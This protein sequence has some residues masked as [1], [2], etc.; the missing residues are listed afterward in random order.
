MDSD[1]SRTTGAMLLLLSLL[2]HILLLLFIFIF[3]TAPR[4]AQQIEYIDLKNQLPLDPLLQ[5][6]QQSQQQQM[7]PYDPDHEILVDLIAQGMNPNDALTEQP[8][9]IVQDTATPIPGTLPQEEVTAEDAQDLDAETEDEASTQETV[10]QPEEPMPPAQETPKEA[11]TLQELAD[12][13][14]A[15]LPQPAALPA[16][17]TA[18]KQAA[19]KIVRKMA[20]RPPLTPAQAQ[21]LSKLAQGFMQSTHAERGGTPSDD[22]AQLATQR[23]TTKI[24][25]YLKQT[26]NAEQNAMVLSKDVNTYIVLKITLNKQGK[27]V[28]VGCDGPQR[29]RDVLK[30]EDAILAAVRK[31]GLFPPMPD[32]FKKDQYTIVLPIHIRLAQGIGTVSLY[33][34]DDR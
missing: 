14:T 11:F 33:V 31:V 2:L 25:N 6:Q 15:Q 27:L 24:W 9:E 34:Q 32:S 10:E 28:D 7:D 20:Q 4:D 22:I 18:P 23:Y 8:G 3:Q 13:L 12:T 1:T 21:A 16:K 30:F 19:K 17:P 29:T 26:F 5:Q